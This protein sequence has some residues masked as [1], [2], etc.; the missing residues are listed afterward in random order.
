M[1]VDLDFEV[2]VLWISDQKKKKNKEKINTL[3]PL[4][5]EKC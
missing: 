5:A 2:F 3:C 1:I 4:E